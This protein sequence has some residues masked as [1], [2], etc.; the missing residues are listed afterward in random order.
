MRPERL[1]TSSILVASFFLFCLIFIATSCEKAP[2]KELSVQGVD[3]ALID[4]AKKLRPGET[5][6]DRTVYFYVQKIGGFSNRGGQIYPEILLEI[7]ELKYQTM[8]MGQ[9]INTPSDSLDALTLPLG[10]LGEGTFTVKATIID[11]HSGARETI[12][13]T[14]TI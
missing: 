9:P 5:A 10:V 2:E 1:S 12:T 8:F 4:E 7:P 3:F 13:R 14:L 6:P 11:R